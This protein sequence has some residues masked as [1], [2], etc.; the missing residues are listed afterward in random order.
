MPKEERERHDKKLKII[1]KTKDDKQKRLE[2]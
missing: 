2:D 1:E